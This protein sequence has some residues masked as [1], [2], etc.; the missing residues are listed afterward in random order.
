M[1]DE[2][3]SL[4]IGAP[5]SQTHRAARAA[6]GKATPEAIALADALRARESE[7]SDWLQ[8]PAHRK[9][10]AADPLKSLGQFVPPEVLKAAGVAQRVP[11]E[12]VK[13]LGRLHLQGLAP[14]Q[15][16]AMDLFARVWTFVAASPAN[17]AAFTA[18]IRGTVR[19]AD[20][21]APQPVV[22]E[23]VAAF[24]KVLGIFELSVVSP[25]YFTGRVAEGLSVLRS[26]DLP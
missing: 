19:N 9:V 2:P 25:A 16:P 13:G 11:P 17:L 8:D 15:T 10:L 18:D 14:A 26:I 21:T 3:L 24:D 23:V 7:L 20:T 6:L 1:P 12:V 5:E 22:D 4:S